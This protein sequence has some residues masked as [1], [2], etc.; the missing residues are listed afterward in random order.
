MGPN[1]FRFLCEKGA[2]LGTGKMTEGGALALK[3]GNNE[4]VDDS[5]MPA[6]ELASQAGC[7]PL[8]SSSS[9]FVV[10]FFR[11][12]RAK[13]RRLLPRFADPPVAKKGPPGGP[14]HPETLER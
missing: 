13:H 8:Q 6:G 12:A 11:M 3:G 9:S 14:S 2:K 1:V 7:S 10:G 5:G 4:S